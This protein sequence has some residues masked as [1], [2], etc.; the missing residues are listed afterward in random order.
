MRDQLAANATNITLAGGGL[1]DTYIAYDPSTKVVEAAG[2]GIDTVQTWG[3]GFT[4]S[5]NL[6]NVTLQGGNNS[7]ATGSAGNNLLTGNDGN[8][9][10]TTDGRNDDLV[11]EKDT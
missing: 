5:A 7:T 9:S 6:E 4:P 11:G 8:N 10:I 3:S 2:G 1:D